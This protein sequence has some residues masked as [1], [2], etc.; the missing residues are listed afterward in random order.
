M[1]RLSHQEEFAQMTPVLTLWKRRRR[2][3]APYARSTSRPWSA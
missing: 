1:I 3:G 2:S